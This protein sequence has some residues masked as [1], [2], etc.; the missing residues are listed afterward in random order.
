MI[1]AAAILFRHIAD[2]AAAFKGQGTVRAIHATAVI[3][4]F[5]AVDEACPVD[6]ERAACVIHTTAICC[7]S[8]V[9][10]NGG[11]S[12]I[13]GAACLIQ[14]SAIGSCMAILNSANAALVF[15]SNVEGSTRGH[16]DTAAIGSATVLNLRIGIGIKVKVVIVAGAGEVN[17]PA[18]A[19]RH[20]VGNE[21]AVDQEYPVPHIY[22]AAVGGSRGRIDGI[23]RLAGRHAADAAAGFERK[24]TAV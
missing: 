19:R 6:V 9:P 2:D 4:G 24:G 11:V 8:A 21:A 15:L 5:T 10:D 7:R 1:H 20:T 13:T 12:Q 17:A 3:L 23:P 22:A 14:A 18:V 16:V